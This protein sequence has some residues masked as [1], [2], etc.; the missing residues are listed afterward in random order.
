MVGLEIRNERYE[1]YEAIRARLPQ[2]RS[3]NMLRRA[4][5]DHHWFENCVRNTRDRLRNGS[6]KEGESCGYQ[7]R[8]DRNFPNL[9]SELKVVNL[10]QCFRSDHDAK[11]KTFT[12]SR[13]FGNNGIN[14]DISDLGRR[15]LILDVKKGGGRSLSYAE[16]LHRWCCRLAPKRA[17]R[18]N[19]TRWTRRVSWSVA[20]PPW[21][22][23]HDKE[24]KRLLHQIFTLN[25]PGTAVT[26]PRT[27]KQRD[28]KQALR[29]S[30]NETEGIRQEGP[31]LRITE[32]TPPMRH[33]VLPAEIKFAEFKK[34]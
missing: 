24:I 30:R 17:E 2:L 33:K 15:M 19:G 22:Y 12:K 29:R 7:P 8:I 18:V 20:G 23:I 6:V 25:S 16:A 28:A 31:E 34:Q 26:L 32:S 21:E 14:T 11:C 3:K 9:L 27:S 4:E 10:W 5:I 1:Q 13:G